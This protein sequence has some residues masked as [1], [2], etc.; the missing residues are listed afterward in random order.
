MKT[1]LG[2][3]PGTRCHST[4]SFAPCTP[5]LAPF[6]NLRRRS[7]SRCAAASKNAPSKPKAGPPPAV[8]TKASGVRQKDKLVPLPDVDVSLDFGMQSD[9]YEAEE[10]MPISSSGA[11]QESK[12]GRSDD[13]SEAEDDIPIGLVGAGQESKRGRSVV[14]ADGTSSLSARWALGK[15][16][17]IAMYHVA[18]GFDRKELDTLLHATYGKASIR[19]YPDCYYVDFD[20]GEDY[21]PGSDIFFFDF[22]DKFQFNTVAE[23][24]NV[25]NVTVALN[26]RFELERDE[27]Q[28]NFS[29][30]EK[31]NVKN[32]TV[33][34]NQRFLERDEFQFNFSVA[35]KPNVKNDTVTLNQRFVKNHKMKLAIT[36]GLA[37]SSKLSIYETRV[38]EIVEDTKTLPEMLAETGKL[39]A[40]EEEIAKLIGKKSTVNLLT[41]VLDTPAFFWHAPDQFQ[42]LYSRTTEYL[43]L[44][45][46]VELLNNRFSILQE[47]L[48]MC[49]ATQNFKH[50]TQ[51]ELVVI[52]LI[53]AEILLFV[54]ENVIKAV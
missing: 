4:H 8:S 54:G 2:S 49:R 41:T 52:W 33:T 15:T 11:G 27:F 48:E 7:T 1:F 3:S 31:P 28:F 10:D 40:S 45:E 24:L 21:E 47:M 36:Y 19:S 6:L 12:R 51:L 44:S 5:R 42:I 34:L 16:A 9:E 29:V 22:R 46:R 18:E 37:Q 13:E 17:S 50:A 35:E 32:D 53:V 23:K 26:H 43:E 14:A 20:T 39:E 30:A 25:N 38:N